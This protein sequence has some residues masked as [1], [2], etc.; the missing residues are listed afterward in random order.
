ME[1]LDNNGLKTLWN[2]IKTYIDNSPAPAIADN[3]QALIDNVLDP[4]REAFG[5]TVR[6]NSGYR[7]KQLNRLVGGVDD[8]QHTTGQA[9][10]ITSKT[11]KGN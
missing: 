5:S 6:V 2:K 10:D 9:A 4:A 3:L 8:S 11:K 7:S 1:F